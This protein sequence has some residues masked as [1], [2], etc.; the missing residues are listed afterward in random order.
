MGSLARPARSKES[1]LFGRVAL[2]QALSLTAAVVLL[3]TAL[4]PP[5][6]GQPAQRPPNVTG[7]V[8]DAFSMGPLAGARVAAGPVSV[9]TDREGRFALTVPEGPLRLVVTAEGH[10]TEQVDVVVTDQPVSVEVLLLSQ[11]Q[12]K[13]DVVVTAG[14]KP[15]PVSP[16]TIDVSPL[17]VRSIAGAAENIFRTVQTLPG[18][19]A[20]DDFGSRLSVRGGGPDQNLTVMDG[21]EIHDP[22]RLF[23]LTSAFNPET[24]ENF[25]FVAGG[26]SPKYGD[27]LSS[28]LVVENRAGTRTKPLAGSFS[29][30]LTDAN[31]V[32]EG[33]LPGNASGSWI[34]SARRTY[35]DLVANRI[36][37]TTLPAFNDLQAKVSWD[38]RPNQ[39]LSLFV[40]R[41]RER[42]DAEFDEESTSSRTAS[43][44]PR[45]RR[46]AICRRRCRGTC[47]RT[48]ACRC[49]CSAAGSGP[50][51]SST[52]S[53]APPPS[54]SATRRP[55]TSFP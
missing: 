40:L 2:R 12:F 18:V 22:Y 5:A 13:E 45:S 9:A 24:I 28:I 51:R 21:V 42:T 26:F 37:G 41:S 54:G 14:L 30:A 19:N 15:A 38:L 31:V 4:S 48:T 55:T 49:S 33:K 23:G 39:R 20:A 8:I 7:R 36:V 16:S 34:V 46:S 32:L 47:D 44:A 35:Y 53:P 11:S 52:R 50:T 3:L 6:S 25:E 17:A 29:L 1:C 10:L 27:R 43:S